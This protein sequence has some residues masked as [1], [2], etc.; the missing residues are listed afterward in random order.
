MSGPEKSGATTTLYALLRNHDPFLNSINTLEKQPSSALLNVTQNTYTL[1]DTGTTTY[2][3]RLATIVRMGPDIV[4]I[5]ECEDA[6]T[7]Q[8]A[9]AAA[10]DGK[11]VYVML[12]ADSVLQ[13]LGKWMKLVGD[14]KLVA[15]T[16]LGVSNQRLLRKLCDQCKQA[17]TPNTDLL[18]KFN[19]PA[20]KAKV[21][22]RP[23][24]EVYDKKGKP[25]TCPGC[26]GTGFVGRTAIF[27][28]VT[29]DEELRKV[30]KQAK[31]LPE[32]MIFKPRRAAKASAGS[33]SVGNP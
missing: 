17:Y 9:A 25:M 3:Q 28:M 31:A 18:K 16:L 13:A 7:A 4:G 32:S 27:E 15:G 2:S 30:I 12:K 14:R 1:S 24:K 26:Q 8:V 22:Y 6:E 19:L 11:L 20:D 10:K 23:G 21:L 29:I 33:M 5:G